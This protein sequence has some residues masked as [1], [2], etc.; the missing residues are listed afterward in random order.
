MIALFLFAITRTTMDYMNVST[1]NLVNLTYYNQQMPD[2]SSWMISTPDTMNVTYFMNKMPDFSSWN[3]SSAFLLPSTRDMS[4]WAV[5]YFLSGALFFFASAF[6]I[7]PRS[8]QY[9]AIDGIA[10]MS[11]FTK[12]KQRYQNYKPNREVMNL[13]ESNG[14]EFDDLL[15]RLASNRKR[16]QLC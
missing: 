1:S 6:I 14:M 2:F 11:D 3:T 10:S 9:K 16:K 15:S 13:V 8:N 4:P 5:Y 7:A 12:T